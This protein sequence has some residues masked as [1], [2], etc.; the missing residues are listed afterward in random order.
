VQEDRGVLAH[1]PLRS[2]RSPDLDAV[3][4]PEASPAVYNGN[5]EDVSLHRIDGA[6]HRADYTPLGGGCFDR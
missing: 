4:E 2:V 6:K 1:V 3:K 5:V